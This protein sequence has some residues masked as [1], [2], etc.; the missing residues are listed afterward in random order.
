MIGAPGV[1]NWFGTVVLYQDISANRGDTVNL[2]DKKIVVE[3]RDFY[4]HLSE[5]NT[6]RT[7]FHLMGYSV[8]SGY[9]F[10]SKNLYYAA[11]APRY[12]GVGKVNIRSII[13]HRILIPSYFSE[14]IGYRIP[15]T[16]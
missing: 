7:F 5:P 16:I 11:S 15:N 3:P 4:P 9:Y 2:E 13:I 8:T 1:F 14:Y 10:G 12:A 6:K